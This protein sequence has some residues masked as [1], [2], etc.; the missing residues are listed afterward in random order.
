MSR[1]IMMLLLLL[2]LLTMMVGVVKCQKANNISNKEIRYA[3]ACLATHQAAYVITRQI[4]TEPI[5]SLKTSRCI[6]HGTAAIARGL[7]HVLV[8]AL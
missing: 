4:F 5:P 6:T 7:T 8:G 3:P 1:V 2:L